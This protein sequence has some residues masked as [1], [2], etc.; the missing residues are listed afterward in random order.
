MA[1]GHH[2]PDGVLPAHPATVTAVMGDV[3][4]TGMGDAEVAPR[5]PTCGERDSEDIGEDV[6]R[7]RHCTYV[8]IPAAPEGGAS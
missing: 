1:R 5:C 8:W 2:D 7:C 6:H 4:D 3:V